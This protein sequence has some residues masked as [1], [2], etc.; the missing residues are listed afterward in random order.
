MSRKREAPGKGGL[1]AVVTHRPATAA[2]AVPES[3]HRSGG[4]A[5]CREAHWWGGFAHAR[6]TQLTAWS[7]RLAL[8]ASARWGG[9]S[10]DAAVVAAKRAGVCLAAAGGV[11]PSRPLCV[12]RGQRQDPFAAPGPSLG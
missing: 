12:A 8:V 3:A 6:L 4:A 11:A 1:G 5:G 9:P 10:G 7:R 2:H